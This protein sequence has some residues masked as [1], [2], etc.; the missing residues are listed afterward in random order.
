[1]FDFIIVQ[2]TFSNQK[3]LLIKCLGKVWHVIFQD[4]FLEEGA[5]YWCHIYL[6]CTIICKSHFVC[7]VIYG[8]YS[9]WS[10]PLDLSCV[11]SMRMF[12]TF[13]CYC[14]CWGDYK[15]TVFGIV[16]NFLCSM[17]I[18]GLVYELVVHNKT[19]ELFCSHHCSHN[20]NY[21]GYQRIVAYVCAVCVEH[22]KWLQAH[23]P[24]IWH[25]HCTSY[26]SC[27]HAAATVAPI[28]QNKN[29]NHVNTTNVL[30]TQII[31]LSLL[32][33]LDF[34]RAVQL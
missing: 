7:H 3:Q 27:V 17:S 10:F 31:A 12:H 4:L 9:W 21:Q 13:A 25:E 11:N 30:Q 23:L 15:P 29:A 16:G 26:I 14:I 18:S 34:A 19:F 33:G 6:E 2:N 32:W 24:I 1:M 8:I 22:F 28:I 20:L 5:I